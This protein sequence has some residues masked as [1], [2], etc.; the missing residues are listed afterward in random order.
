ME[1]APNANKGVTSSVGLVSR[2]T[3]ETKN[4]SSLSPWPPKENVGSTDVLTFSSS[5][6]KDVLKAS[7]FSPTALVKR[8]RLSDAQDSTTRE[9]VSSV[10]NLYTPLTIKVSAFQSGVPEST[11]TDSVTLVTPQ[12]GT[13]LTRTD[14]VGSRTV[15][16]PTKKVAK[17]AKEG[18]RKPS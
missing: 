16:F 17:F 10:W 13:L 7:L 6:A 1:L 4:V 8:R 12:E 5:D 14:T 3:A 11:Q 9:N 15:W 2:L 18:S